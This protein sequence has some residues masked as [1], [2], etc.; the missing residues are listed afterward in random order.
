MSTEHEE[1]PVALYSIT[2]FLRRSIFAGSIRVIGLICVFALQVLLARIIGDTEEYGKYAWGQSLLFL[3][4]SLAAMGLPVVTGR[5]VASLRIT[6]NERGIARIVHRAQVLLLRSSGLLILGAL[7]IAGLS[8]GSIDLPFY[9]H[10]AVLALLFAPAISFAHLYQDLCRA[11]E[12]LGLALTPLNVMRPVVTAVLAVCVW[13]LSHHKLVGVTVLGIAGSSVV[14]VLLV[15][16]SLYRWRTR[17]LQVNRDNTTHQPDYH[18]SRLFKT[19]LPV[20]AMRCAGLTMTYSNV[21]LVGFLAGPAAAG[22]YFAAERLAQLA[23]IPHSVV[24]AV[25]QQSMAAA[26]AARN[27]IELQKVTTQ[28][29]HGSL[30][31]TA[32][33]AVALCVLATQLLQLFGENFSAASIVLITLVAGNVFSIAMGPA[34]DVL[35]M[36]GRQYLVPKV[37]LIAA[38]IHVLALFLLVPSYGAFGAALASLASSIVANAW[39]ALLAKTKA[40][41]GTTVL[42]SGVK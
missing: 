19:A 25:N 20:F 21:L 30:W 13:Q 17:Q 34:Q 26:H 29:A 5:F 8:W 38:V 6:K 36:T 22:A 24:S 3:A 33:I 7:T 18:P 2:E 11:R 10:L 37:M 12:W 31:P 35:L 1:R 23:A 16:I 4:G 14:I 28:S 40:G 41:I 32:C 27:T 42:A 39:L 15:Q 9:A